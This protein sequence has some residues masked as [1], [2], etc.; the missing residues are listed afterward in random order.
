[1]EKKISNCFVPDY[2][3]A[4]DSNCNVENKNNKPI[5]STKQQTFFFIYKYALEQRFFNFFVFVHSYQEFLYVIHLLQEILN[6]QY[7]FLLK[8][9]FAT[10]ANLFILFEGCVVFFFES[11]AVY[12]IFPFG[13]K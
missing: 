9:F 7:L 3:L 1:M 12:H 4:R 5:F 8:Y 2:S 10:A 11:S 6:F 13:P